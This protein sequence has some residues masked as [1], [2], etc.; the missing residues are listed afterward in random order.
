M[1]SSVR[2]GAS[3]DGDDDTGAMDTRTRRERNAA[4]AAAAAAALELQEH[5]RAARAALELDT[6]M[7][8]N[9]TDKPIGDD[10]VGELAPLIG[11][12]QKLTKV[13]YVVPCAHEPSRP[14]ARVPLC[15]GV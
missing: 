11:R 6:D 5:V 10:A 2:S 9:M 3:V 8:I 14:G 7:T 12:C 1:A 13:M 4:A 15:H